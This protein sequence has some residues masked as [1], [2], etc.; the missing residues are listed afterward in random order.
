MKREFENVT[1]P[2]FLDEQKPRKSWSA[3][4]QISAVSAVL[5]K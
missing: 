1:W 3:A 2:K 4:K 5:R